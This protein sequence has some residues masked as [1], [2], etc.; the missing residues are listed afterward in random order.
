MSMNKAEGNS[1]S[2]EFF[3]VGLL[4]SLLLDDFIISA[5]LPKCQHVLA[6]ISLLLFIYSDSDF[7]LVHMCHF[8][9]KQAS[10]KRICKNIRVCVCVCDCDSCTQTTNAHARIQFVW[11]IPACCKTNTV[12]QVIHVTMLHFCW[13][14]LF[15]SDYLSTLSCV[16]LH[17][18][19][20]PLLLQTDSPH[21]FYPAFL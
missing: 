15:V 2:L 5:S 13:F 8:T 14:S 10:V 11:L 20:S 16:S 21:P 4:T 6:W 9:F 17:I 18:F 7:M 3:S 1:A 12:I 19:V